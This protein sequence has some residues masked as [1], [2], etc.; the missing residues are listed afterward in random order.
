MTILVR[1]V[2]GELRHSV[3]GFWIR[4]SSVRVPVQFELS[5]KP[6]GCGEGRGG[7]SSSSSSA[8]VPV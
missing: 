3:L 4:S 5:S 2:K 8:R 6:K 7:R 1:R